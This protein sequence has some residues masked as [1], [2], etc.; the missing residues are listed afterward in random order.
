MQSF[1]ILAEVAVGIAGFGSIAIV[2]ARDQAGWKSADFFR[3]SALLLASLGALFL[4]L[5]PVGLAT[6]ELAAPLI[7]R[8]ASALLAAYLAFFTLLLLRWRNRYLDRALWFGRPLFALVT[9]TTFAN[10]FAQL[11]NVFGLVYQP[12][13]TAY[14]FGIVWFLA[15]ACLMLA[16]VFFLRPTES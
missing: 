9:V 12:N 15:Y 4:A 6:S 7:W 13:A 1:E 8:F 5:L 2:L 14:Y 16:R 3:V 11:A 10:L